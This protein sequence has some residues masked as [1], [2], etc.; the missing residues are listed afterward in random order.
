MERLVRTLQ[1]GMA[2]AAVLFVGGIVTWITHLIRTAWRLG[3]VPSASIGIALVAIP[4]FL[5]LLGVIVYVFWGLLSE[6]HAPAPLAAAGRDD[7]EGTERPRST[8][9]AVVL[10]G[11]L[12]SLGVLGARDASAGH[13]ALSALLPA[14]PLDGSRLFA[15]KG[16]PSCHAVHG[17][18]GIAGP[19]F[20]RANLSRPLLDIAGA[21]WNHSPGMEHAFQERR[22]PR[23]T[24]TPS[25]MA[26]LLS[27]LYYVGSLDPPGDAGTG[28][29]LFRQKACE[30][31]HALG[32]KGGR[33]GP[34]L[35][36]YSRYA[37]PLYLTA[38][39]WNHAQHMAEAMRA[40]R[41]DRP[42]FAGSDLPDLL[43][44]I[45]SA[46]GSSE[47]VYIEP[48]SPKRGEALFRS[49]RCVECHAARGHGG[50][51]GPDLGVVLR[52]S[53]M[54]IAGGMWNHAPHMWPKMVER[55][56]AVPSLTPEEMSDLVSYLYYFQF[57]DA[58]GDAGRG[59]V[60]F[61]EKRCGACHG[62]SA[63]GKPV[64]SPLDEMPERFRSP[65]EVVTRMWNHAGRMEGKTAEENLA[66]PLLKAGETA[67]LVA[68]LL[69]P[70][71][72]PGPSPR[73]K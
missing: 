11:L 6:R 27:F 34:A 70:R 37:S 31:C 56:I 12:V 61:K 47:R 19:D 68:Y 4:V 36:S 8:G 72:I 44:Y 42:T 3:D 46:G 5:T 62:S 23:P 69:S 50:A 40:R 55:G 41:L 21:M 33:V 30:A 54:R 17:V 48:G 51:L 28:E 22:M 58:P 59:S 71:G 52:G 49:R 45:R 57:I 43:A 35:D 24:L 60:V 1:W 66:W 2:L 64:A 73:K 63:A 14:N 39:I 15:A 16:C 38:A 20:G 32:G 29:R 9:V 53:L 25:E 67:D 7:D 10:L 65:L 13:E 26:S 18:G